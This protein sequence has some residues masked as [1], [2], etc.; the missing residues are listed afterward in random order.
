MWSDRAK[1]EE[2]SLQQL[3]HSRMVLMDFLSHMVG[4]LL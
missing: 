1:E 3:L 4:Q 2:G